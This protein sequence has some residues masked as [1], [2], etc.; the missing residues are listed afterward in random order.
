[1]LSRLSERCTAATTLERQVLR[2]HVWSA[3][4]LRE[5]EP[6]AAA[7]QDIDLSQLMERAGRAAYD[8]FATLYASQR[9]W[10]VVV[11]PGNNGGDGYVIAR[12]ARAAGKR[13]TV[14]SMPHTKPLPTEAANAQRAWQAAGGTEAVLD[15]DVPL[16]LPG[17]VDLVVDGLLGTGI[18]GP[19]RAHYEDVIRRLNA[20]AVP[21]VA[22]DIPSG[23]NAE[24]GEAAGACLRADHTATFI[25]L[26]PGLLTGQAR[27]YV[28]QL[29]YRSL[30]LEAWLTAPERVAACQCRRVAVEDV[31]DY[32]GAPRSASAHKGSCGKVVLVGGDHGCGGAIL[33]S[34]EACLT[35]GAGLTRVLTRPEHVTPLLTRCPEVMVVA[36]GPEP[37]DDALPLLRRQMT[38]AFGWA[39]TVA[40]GPGIGTGAYGRAAVAAALRHGAAHP[41]ATIVLDADALNLLA[42]RIRGK[43]QAATAGGA[44][45]EEK[46]ESAPLPTLRN[47]IITPHPGEAARLLCCSVAAVEQDRLAAARRLASILGGT[48]LLKG[49]G[50]VVHDCSSGRTAIV[51]AGNAGMASG[52]MGDVL[53]GLVAGLAAQQM[54]DTFDITCASALAHGVAADMVAADAG[55]GTRGI[56]AT[57]LIQRFPFILNASRAAS[58]ATPHPQPEQEPQQPQPCSGL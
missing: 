58:S 12:H 57:E 53:T 52:G 46:E 25:S 36:V 55:R 11:G 15:P 6:A 34:A 39:T 16:Q 56:R 30:G 42:E 40:V 31:Y 1:M 47:S 3:A 4:W 23:L 48:C 17:E 21:R 7:S 14:F 8:V 35:A 45:V 26:K 13:V 19:P 28:G 18:A 33:M 41:D 9:H 51:D 50:T 20:L 54:R 27:S 22:I 29:H 49:P 24:T 5:A 44:D 10:L 32:F 38:D 2:R 43:D 37:H